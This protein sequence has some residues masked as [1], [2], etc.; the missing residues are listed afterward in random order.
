MTSLARPDD[1]DAWRAIEHRLR[2]FV[3]RRVPSPADAD[4]VLQDIFVRIARGAPIRHE[5]RLTSWLF[6]VARSALADHRRQLARHPHASADRDE[7][8]SPEETA[9]DPLHEELT[10]CVA[11]FVT[12]L[13]D[14]YREAITLVEIEGVA[15]SEAAEMLGLSRSGMKSR[16]QRGRAALR[17][18]F[19]RACALELDARSKVLECEPRN[20]CGCDTEPP[21]RS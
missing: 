21:A 9:P 7:P 5:E 16:V 13:P 14:D 2:P 19:E 3:A 15:Q 18:M 10:A 20:G 4:D 6:A 17:R 8:A 11:R 1:R 12:L